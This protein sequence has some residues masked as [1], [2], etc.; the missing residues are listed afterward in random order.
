MATTAPTAAKVRPAATRV[1]EAARVAVGRAMTVP[2]GMVVETERVVMRDEVAAARTKKGKSAP[3]FRPK[4]G[5]IFDVLV[6][7]VAVE[8]PLAAR[9]AEVVALAARVEVT[10]EEDPTAGVVVAAVATEETAEE[11][12]VGRT[13]ETPMLV[14]MELSPGARVLTTVLTPPMTWDVTPAM[15]ELVRTGPRAK[16]TGE[17]REVT[18]EGR[19]VRVVLRAPMERV[20]RGAWAT[21]GGEKRVSTRIFRLRRRGDE[22]TYQRRRRRRR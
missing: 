7:L 8:V 19:T 6:P 9:V 18:W 4:E 1:E 20:K 5:I 17:M 2:V 21:T 13:M 3:S 22:R 15:A 11:T 16:V 12:P 10:T 14:R